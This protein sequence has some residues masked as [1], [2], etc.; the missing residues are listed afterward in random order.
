MSILYSGESLVVADYRCTAKCGERPFIECHRDYS[1]SYVRKGAFA[2]HTR[3]R[4]FDLVAGSVLLGHAGDEYMC[5]HEHVDGDECLSITID[6]GFAETL[7]RTTSTWRKAALPPLAEL[8]VL[9]QL[10]EASASGVSDLGVDEAATYLIGRALALSSDRPNDP[11]RVRAADRRRVIAAALWIDSRFREGINLE[12][13][14]REAEL[15]PYHFLRLFGAVLGVTPHQY[16]VRC[17]LR[18]AA[19]LLA[20]GDLPITDVALEV[21][22]RDL[23]NFIRTFR[24]AAGV[25]PREFR[26]TA[27]KRST[28]LAT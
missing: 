17:R 1:V 27:L 6:P 2:Y 18:R 16:L 4:T 7:T 8:V 24:R 12:M 26:R 3:G 9:G 10:A 22:F 28:G 25:P 15:S 23:S 14:A 11:P 21:G 20:E 5:S 19:R 13:A